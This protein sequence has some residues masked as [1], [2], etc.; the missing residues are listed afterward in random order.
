MRA[1]KQIKRIAIAGIAAAFSAAAAVAAH[2]IAISA[3]GI[4]IGF[5]DIGYFAALGRV[6]VPA[7]ASGEIALIDPSS[8]AVERI[9]A[10]ESGRDRGAGH[11]DGVT[12]ADAG[13][14]MIFATD[15]TSRTLEVFDSHSLR[16]I[17]AAPLAG[18]PDYVRYIATTREVWVT[19]PSDERIEVFRADQ[20]ERITHAAFIAIVGGPESLVADTNGGRAYTNLWA[21]TTLA[22]DLATREIVARWPNGCRGSRGIAL[23]ATRGFVLAGCDEGRVSV[24]DRKTGKQLGEARAG[25]G[26]DIIAYDATRGRAYVPGADSATMTIVE[27]S[28]AGRARVL[29]ELPT[30]KGA[31]C[32]ATFAGK[33]F[34]C[35]P[36]HGA[37][38]VLSDP[39]PLSGS[40]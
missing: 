13:T 22:I 19:E 40:K 27:I 36:S 11:G 30:V 14:G 10:F 1:T 21:G 23:D 20:P 7:G 34:V 37:I 3:A 38:L 35:D 32:A 17:G 39:Y 8:L 15:R 5:D 31:H 29:G 4:R 6:M 18:G 33:V 28:D 24:L 25:A 2:S 9:R 16:R 26:V 12:S